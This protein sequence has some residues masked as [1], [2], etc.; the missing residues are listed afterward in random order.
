MISLISLLVSGHF[1]ISVSCSFSSSK[2]CEGERSV[3]NEQLERSAYL[4]TYRRHVCGCPEGISK[5]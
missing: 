4:V 5:L 3:L 1:G 2:S